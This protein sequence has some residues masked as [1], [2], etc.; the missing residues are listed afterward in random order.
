MA[1]AGPTAVGAKPQGQ[2]E[3]RDALAGKQD[4]PAQSAVS[5][6]I[7]AAITALIIV[8]RVISIIIAGVHFGVPFVYSLLKF[9]ISIIDKNSRIFIEKH[10]V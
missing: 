7:M 1:V 9:N 3:N 5:P 6:M 2:A 8:S 4:R 10:K